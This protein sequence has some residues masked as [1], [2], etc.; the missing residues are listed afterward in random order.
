MTTHVQVSISAT[1][2]STLTHSPVTRPSSAPFAQAV[3]EASGTGSGTPASDHC[4]AQ[5]A[6]AAP[7]GRSTSSPK[8][9]E[10]SQAGQAIVKHPMGKKLAVSA[11]NAAVGSS[12]P[13][14]SSGAVTSPIPLAGANL[15]GAAASGMGQSAPQSEAAPLAASSAST[16]LVA[17]A[18]ASGLPGLPSPSSNTWPPGFPDTN[19]V[20]ESGA[21]GSTAAGAVQASNSPAD[22]LE[23]LASPVTDEEIQEES[24]EPG[25][26]QADLQRSGPGST[27]AGD[28]VHQ[29]SPA[30]SIP[31]SMLPAREAAPHSPEQSQAVGSVASL[32]PGKAAPARTQPESRSNRA[33]GVTPSQP[34]L[35]GPSSVRSSGQTPTLDAHQGEAGTAGFNGKVFQERA[36]SVASSGVSLQGE[37]AFPISGSTTNTA[38]TGAPATVAI[39]TLSPS[40]WAPNGSD[41]DGQA[42]SSGGTGKVVFSGSATAGEAASTDTDPLALASAI[43]PGS[44][45]SAAHGLLSDALQAPPANLPFPIPSASAAIQSRTA[46]ASVQE[47]SPLL[48]HSRLLQS[49][50]GSQMQV[51]LESGDFGRI[52]MHA[53]YGRNGLSAEISVDHAELASTIAAHFPGVEQRLVND[54]GLATSLRLSTGAPST[55]ANNAPAGGQDRNQSGGADQ[56]AP[57]AAAGRGRTLTGLSLSTEL[58]EKVPTSSI[59]A[60][61]RAGS[62]GR[63]DIRI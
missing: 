25:V 58:S 39:P 44:A 49:V 17:S 42:V 22:Q 5:A 54:H 59:P 63:L 36:T 34:M 51:Q 41:I 29:D 18:Q 24:Q 57:R 6:D 21:I 35:S 33:W 26:A 3:Q 13:S 60:K 61:V 32:Q 43:Q 52:T 40:T 23:P 46:A 10:P 62:A 4:T 9:S 8:T 28:A 50:H 11:S 30:L 53:G 45:A 2:V 16:A 20:L 15:T 48:T 14:T 7:P 56:N 31:S 55:A 27:L 1:R 38:L 47:I 19:G 37:Y 12:L